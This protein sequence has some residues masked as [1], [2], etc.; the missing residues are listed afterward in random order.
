MESFQTMWKKDHR[1]PLQHTW[2]LWFRDFAQDLLKK[3]TMEWLEMIGTSDG[4]Y[5][6]IYTVYMS[7]YLVTNH[8]PS[9]LIMILYTPEI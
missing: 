2:K 8:N 4:R 7:Y 9:N 3:T 6:Y 5:V 1:F